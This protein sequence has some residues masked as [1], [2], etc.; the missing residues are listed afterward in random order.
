MPLLQRF[1]AAHFL[2]VHRVVDLALVVVGK[3]RVRVLDVLEG[4]MSGRFLSDIAVRM[5]FHRSLPVRALDLF[6]GRVL[7]HA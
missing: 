1:P 5:P 3:D 2:R 7:R 4:C 6:R